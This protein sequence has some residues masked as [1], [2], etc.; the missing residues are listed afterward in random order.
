MVKA[1]RTVR[2]AASDEGSLATWETAVTPQNF[3]PRTTDQ[4]NFMNDLRERKTVARG[5][6]TMEDLEKEKELEV[7]RM[8]ST[9][10]EES[11]KGLCTYSRFLSMV[12]FVNNTHYE[13]VMETRRAL[14][15]LL[16]GKET[17]KLEFYMSVMWMMTDDQYT[18]FSEY[19]VMDSF[20]GGAT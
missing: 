1:I 5:N 4:I 16:T 6:R 10:M 3:M 18:H 11:Q 9:T 13:G 8:P 15:E 17:I 2:L 19:T 14:N 7:T 20:E 12:G